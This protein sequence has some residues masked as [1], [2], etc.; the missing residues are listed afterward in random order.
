LGGGYASDYAT[1]SFVKNSLITSAK[2]L[3]QQTDMK[4]PSPVQVLMLS[5]LAMTAPPVLLVLFRRNIRPA[6][7]NPNR[8][9]VEASEAAQA[10]TDYKNTT[11]YQEGRD[12][13]KTHPNGAYMYGLGGREDYVSANIADAYPS[14]EIQKLIDEGVQPSKIKKIIYG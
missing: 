7:N 9:K 14:P 6:S 4:P 3:A 10:Q 5:L 12:Q 11:E 8:E 1:S 2:E 13:F